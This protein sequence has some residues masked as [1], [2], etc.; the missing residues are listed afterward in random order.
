MRKESRQSWLFCDLTQSWSEKGGGVRTYLLRKRDYIVN[1][2]SHR[3]LLIIPGAKDEVIEEGRAITVTIKSPRVPGS[4][5]YRLLFRNRAVRAA[6]ERFKPDLIECE[7][8]YN[9]PW[10][11]IGYRRRN[12]ATVLTAVYMTDFPAAYV[13]R[14]LAKLIGR[15]FARG[16]AALSYAYCKRLYGK[17]DRVFALGEHG[18]AR[19]LRAL[20]IEQVAVVGLG[21]D[22]DGLGPQY[23]D[24][25]LRASL[26]VGDDQPL[27]IY[28]GRLDKEKRPDVVVDAFRKLPTQLGAHLVLIGDGPLRAPI[29]AIGDP[30]IHLPGFVTDRARL[31][32]W[33]ASADLYA[34]AMAFETFG[35]SIL[36]AQASGLPVAG[37]A[38]GAMLDRIDSATGLLGAVGDAEAMAAN[39]L[40]LWNG[41]RAAMAKAAQKRASGHDWGIVMR[42]LFDDQYGELLRQ[43]NDRS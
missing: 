1:H 5:N 8:A 17:F 9:L 24:P 22:L 19:Q 6:L 13:E 36:E 10:A 4:P 11:A 39:L 21:A 42:R 38:S 40:A 20:G 37:I 43:R 33:L 35:V 14:P 25:E 27:I 7:D 15:R 23:R 41:D 18:G 2:T 3:H 28:V 26:G 34:S 12:P 32:R 31:A 16:A 29:A 30:R